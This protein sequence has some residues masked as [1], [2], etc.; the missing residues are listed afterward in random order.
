MGFPGLEPSKTDAVAVDC[1]GGS[2]RVR[3][4]ARVRARVRVHV[5]VCVCVWPERMPT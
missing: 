3:V 2:S 5:C 4:Q 1:L